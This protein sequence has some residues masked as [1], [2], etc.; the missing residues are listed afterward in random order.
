MGIHELYEQIAVTSQKIYEALVRKNP[1]RYYFGY[2]R[3]L[4]TAE[5]PKISYM[6][7]Y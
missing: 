1:M 2:A 5:A 4:V 6:N 3:Y 7:P